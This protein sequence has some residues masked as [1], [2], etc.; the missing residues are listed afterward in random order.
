MAEFDNGS[1][2]DI[3]KLYDQFFTNYNFTK[4]PDYEKT[5]GSNFTFGG[6]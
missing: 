5:R 2:K 6:I 3:I 1:E 4:N